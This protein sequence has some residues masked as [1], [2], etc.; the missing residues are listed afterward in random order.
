MTAQDRRCGTCRFFRP[1]SKKS[2]V[3]YCVW[4]NEDRLP[5]WMEEYRHAVYGTEWKDCPTWEARDAN[6]G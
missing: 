2:S 1:A 6:P 4:D 3:G 5:G